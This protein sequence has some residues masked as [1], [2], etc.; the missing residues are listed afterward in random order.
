M[1]VMGTVHD[2][3][4]ALTGL[5]YTVEVRETCN[6]KIKDPANPKVNFMVHKFWFMEQ[7]VTIKFYHTGLFQIYGF[8][9]TPE[10]TVERTRDCFMAFIMHMIRHVPDMPSI[11][12]YQMNPVSAKM[13][14]HPGLTSFG[15]GFDTPSIK[16]AVDR[17]CSANPNVS[18]KF[19]RANNSLCVKDAGNGCTTFFASGTL[20]VMGVQD[21][22]VALAFATSIILENPHVIRVVPN[23]ARPVKKRKNRDTN[24]TDVPNNTTAPA[25]KRMNI[26]DTP[27][28]PPRIDSEIEDLLNTLT[29]TDAAELFNSFVPPETPMDLDF[30]TLADFVFNPDDITVVTD[31][32][33]DKAEVLLF[34]EADLTS[35][36][37]EA[38]EID[39]DVPTF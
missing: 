27:S 28:P 15:L 3:C 37:E 19:N 24:T 20:Q 23:E 17:N 39:W 26:P 33:E 10:A 9:E 36:D 4:D 32:D 2:W 12:H 34:N 7:P 11:A 18:A 6:P 38:V 14:T 1:G 25:L 8:V 13:G 30:T 35:S 29:E 22:D 16:E 31:E 21:A 5:T